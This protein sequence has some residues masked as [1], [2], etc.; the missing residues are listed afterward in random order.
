MKN[1]P[2]C[3]AEI[4]EEAAFCTNCG[5]ALSDAQPAPTAA[6]EPVAPAA[7]TAAAE[8]VAPAAPAAAAPT[9]PAQP[10]QPVQPAAVQP[11]AAPYGAYQPPQATK[12]GGLKWWHILLIVVAALT[13]AAV[14]FVAVFSILLK[15]DDKKFVGK[16]ETT[17]DIGSYISDELLD[18]LGSDSADMAEYFD[19]DSFEVKMLVEFKDDGTYKLWLDKDTYEN[20]VDSFFDV[21]KSGMSDYFKDMLAKENI[22]MT[23]EDLFASQGTTFDEF[24][25][26]LIDTDDILEEIDS[27][28]SEGNYTTDEGKLYMTD[29]SGKEFDDDKYSSYEFG[30]NNEFTLISSTDDS[31]FDFND[32][33]VAVFPM[34]FSKVA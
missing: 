24:V 33:G 13:A 2:Y 3:N 19:I 5:K 1:C 11:A 14:G 12:K 32:D 29:G 9:A 27:A 17:I 18:S 28:T 6:A 30:G 7:P 31:A 15:S 22:D 16:W 21:I 20:S 4:N 8:P 34:T 10:V 23:L 25:D 26:S